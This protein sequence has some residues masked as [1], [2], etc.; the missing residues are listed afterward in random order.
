MN[1]AC[2]NFHLSAK[3]EGKTKHAKFAAGFC[4]NWTVVGQALHIRQVGEHQPD[5]TMGIARLR[6]SSITI[7]PASSS[8]A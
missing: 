4:S 2:R 7:F 1:C 5:V 8:S 6:P 3:K